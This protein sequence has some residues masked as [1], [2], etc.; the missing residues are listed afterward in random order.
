[1]P[2]FSAIGT[3]NDFCPPARVRLWNLLDLVD[4]GRRT[5]QANEL[6]V[7]AQLLG[8]EYLEEIFVVLCTGFGLF[9][10]FFKC[11]P[12]RDRIVSGFEGWMYCDKDWKR[13][14]NLLYYVIESLK[15]YQAFCPNHS[16]VRIDV[17]IN[18]VTEKSKP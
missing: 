8:V 10:I 5:G 3:V 18:H 13:S 2:K 7:S 14:F 6:G 17:I 15:R 1:F 12:L 11:Q 9:L 16:P 4:D